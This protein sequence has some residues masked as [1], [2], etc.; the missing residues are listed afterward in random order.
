[1]KFTR[2]DQK[3]VDFNVE[4]SNNGDQSLELKSSALA[5]KEKDLGVPVENVIDIPRYKFCKSC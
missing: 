4:V 1:M 5:Q 2:L 3:A